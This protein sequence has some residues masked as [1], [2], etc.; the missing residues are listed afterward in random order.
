MDTNK[1][2]CCSFYLT[3]NSQLLLMLF[4]LFSNSLSILKRVDISFSYPFFF[5]VF[6]QK[7]EKKKKW[8]TDRVMHTS[9]NAIGW[10]T[11][12]LRWDLNRHIRCPLFL[13]LS[14]ISVNFFL[15]LLLHNCLVNCSLRRFSLF[16][17]SCGHY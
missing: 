16:T 10:F 2:A 4:F 7:K 5:I 17:K 15:S 3:N 9:M 14:L 11:T 1:I 13:S 6:F 12:T 8:T